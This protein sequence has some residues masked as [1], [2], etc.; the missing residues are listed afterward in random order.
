MYLDY[1]KR[2]FKRKVYF[3]LQMIILAWVTYFFFSILLAYICRKI[4]KNFY[5]KKFIFSF[6]LSFFTTIWFVTP[7]SENM[8]PIFSI[9]LMDI[10]ESNQLSFQRLIRPFFSLM[11]LFILADLLLRKKRIK[12]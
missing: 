12:S 6:V 4:I 3:K 5:F 8:A 9:F 10:F 2:R 7:G 11:F 1:K